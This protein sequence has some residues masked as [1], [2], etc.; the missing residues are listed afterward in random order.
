MQSKEKIKEQLKQ[1]YLEN[2]EKKKEYGKQYY[3]K[4]KEK[5]KEQLKQWR[6]KNKEYGKQYYLKNKEKHNEQ[7]K[8]WYLKNKNKVIEQNKQWYLNN[9]EKTRI[10]RKKWYL[11]NKE[12]R[13]LYELKYYSLNKSRI[14]KK[15]LIR[16]KQRYHSDEKFR[17]I[18]ILRRR[19]SMALRGFNKSK[20]T[21]KLLGIPNIEFLKN[22]LESKFK[23]NMSWEQR[24]LI[25][26]DHIIP[27]AAFDLTDP[28][29]QS[30]C[31]HYT[32]LQPLWAKENL[33]KGAKVLK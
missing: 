6:L 20:S 14:I 23:P 2:K 9:K 16:E 27:C 10:N 13:K 28:K 4:N 29:Q 7:N 33:S 1:W 24:G 11:K 5:I 21:L 19:I 31:F 26:I 3:L 17:L 15:Q 8:Q 18:H 25:H 32:N 30:K 12:K 22:Y